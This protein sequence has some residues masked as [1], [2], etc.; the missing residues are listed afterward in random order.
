MDIELQTDGSAERAEREIIWRSPSR[1]IV[2]VDLGQSQ[3]PTAVCV[4]E[5]YGERE[6]PAEPTIHRYDVRHLQRLPLGL[7]YP[8]V[9]ADIEMMLQREPLRGAD[10][11]I[12]ETGVGRAV[13]D[14]FVERRMKPIGVQ[15]TAGF[16]D[17]GTMSAWN[18]YT[19]SKSYLV[20]NLDAKLHCGEL[21]FA[22]DLRE[23]PVMETELKDFR[24]RV[25]E[26]GRSTYAA[27]EGQHDD[28]VLAVAIALWR[29]VK[30]KPSFHSGADGPRQERAIMGPRRRCWHWWP[31][32]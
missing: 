14:I 18:R 30:K 4:L 13:G 24:R 15:I 10:L 8:S 29:A 16:D 31:P 21:R 20:S 2:G 6:D 32:F 27:R 5:A 26:T 12:D 25:S 17:T 3:D 1:W 11:V 23:A 22:K 7:S 9:V 28:L 19:V